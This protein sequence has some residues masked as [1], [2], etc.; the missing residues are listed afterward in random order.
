[1][2]APFGNLIDDLTGCAGEE[3]FFEK[4]GWDV[5][6]VGQ[7][8]LLVECLRNDVKLLRFDPADLD[9]LGQKVGE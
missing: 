6:G 2:V 4:R 3:H 7:R 5:S 1:M 9:A 8:G